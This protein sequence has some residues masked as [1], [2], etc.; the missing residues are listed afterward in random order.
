MS[1]PK[2]CAVSFLGLLLSVTLL[3]PPFQARELRTAAQDPA[4]LLAWEDWKSAGSC[5]GVEYLVA[6]SKDD[7]RNDFEEDQNQ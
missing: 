6:I 3:L 5:G 1:L 2:F 4:P 7:G